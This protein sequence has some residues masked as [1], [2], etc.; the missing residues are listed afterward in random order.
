MT[1]KIKTLERVLSNAGVG[2]R[3]EARRWVAAGRVR[4][5]GH[6]S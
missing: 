5:N 3:T 2:S 6:S 1:R 4:V